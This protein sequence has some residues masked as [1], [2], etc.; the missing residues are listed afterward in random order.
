MYRLIYKSDSAVKMNWGIVGGILT[1]STRNNQRSGLTGALLLGK[2]HFLQV[3]EGDFL[4]INETFQRISKD[5][6]HRNI[7]IVSFEVIEQ[8]QF[9]KW[10][11]RGVGVF[12]F[13]PPI[14]QLLIQKYGEEDG[15]IRFPEQGWLAMSLLHDLI[16]LPDLPEWSH[17]KPAE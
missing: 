7:R 13:D 3:L 9:A 5:Q 4:E 8:R 10:D 17:G 14:S 16:L 2:R 11:L 12:D 6:R 1:A 15:E